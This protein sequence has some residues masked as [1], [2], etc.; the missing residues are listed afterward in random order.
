MN[1]IVVTTVRMF[2]G[3]DKSFTDKDI[4]SGLNLG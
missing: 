4:F 1:A 3:I 2:E